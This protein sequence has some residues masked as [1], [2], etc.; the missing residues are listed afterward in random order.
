MIYKFVINFLKSRFNLKRLF[1]LDRKNI[2]ILIFISFL[3][4]NIL[5][6]LDE[7]VRTFNYLTHLGDWIALLS[8]TILFLILPLILYIVFRK[9]KKRLL[10]AFIGFSPALLLI[11][12]QILWIWNKKPCPRFGMTDKNK[13]KSIRLIAMLISLINSVKNN[14]FYKR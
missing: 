6:F 13:V 10:I 1:L 2:Y 7:G 9:S 11:I 14:I 8:Y 3:I 5:A 4:T 12:I